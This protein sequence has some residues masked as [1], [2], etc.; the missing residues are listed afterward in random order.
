MPTC[1]SC[2]ANLAP[3]WKY[4]IHCGALAATVSPRRRGGRD[5]YGITIPPAIRPVGVV[6]PPKSGPS[7]PLL[8]V[9]GL[10]GTALIVYLAILLFGPK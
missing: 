10:A 4:C 9:L 2:G 6:E 5:E 1:L 7:V 8:V 3:Q